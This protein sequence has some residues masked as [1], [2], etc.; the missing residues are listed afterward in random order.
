MRAKKQMKAERINRWR[1]KVLHGQFMRQTNDMNTEKRWVWL[2]GGNLKR[3]TE[4]LIFAA[5]EQ[6]LRT[7]LSSNR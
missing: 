7:N 2:K 4:S 5:Q 1:E 6:A 3:E